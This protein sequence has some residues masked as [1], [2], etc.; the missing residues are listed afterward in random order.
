[1]PAPICVNPWFKFS[2]D[3]VR[4]GFN[5][6][7]KKTIHLLL[8]V[9][10]LV[11]TAAQGEPFVIGA[12]LSALT[13]I[14]S[15]GG[16]Y[17]DGGVEKDILVL[18]KDKGFNT[19]RLR[20][21]VDP[22]DEGFVINDL[23]YT[24]A[25]A[26]RVEM[27]GLKIM[28]D[29]HYSDTWA[30]PGDQHKP[31][32]WKDLSYD[33][34]KQQVHDYTQSVILAFQKENML[35]E[36]VQI[37]NEVQPG[38]LWPDGR[39]AWNDT[40]DLQWE[41]FTGLLKAAISGLRAVATQQQS[42]VIIHYANGGSKMAVERFFTNIEKH[43]VPYDIVGLSYYPWH[44]G[45]FKG[46]EETLAYI[47]TTLDKDVIIA[48]TAYSHRIITHKGKYQ[49]LAFPQTPEGQRDF[50]EELTRMV[51]ATPGTHGRGICYWHPESVQ[52]EGHRIWKGGAAAL[53][54]EDGNVLS[55]ASSIGK[56]SRDWKK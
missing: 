19:V 7:M 11:S 8:S 6:R 4:I 48:E 2:R 38:M 40:G 27:H 22:N 55:A 17:R 50:L 29:F 1:M 18:L 45:P 43:Q 26:R 16:T 44:H 3:S 54:D 14:E 32:A 46:L 13:K 9:V 31:A 28:L 30:D 23:D 35:P 47:G 49:D 33:E 42:K 51:L 36:Y 34:L 52:V 21:F 37:G 39:I 10:L 25:L 41:K 24:L 56:V 53:F 15:L 20:L 5:G 12:D